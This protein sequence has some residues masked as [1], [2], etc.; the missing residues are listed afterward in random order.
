M[1]VVATTA[2]AL[3]AIVLLLGLSS[4]WLERTPIPLSLLALLYGILLGPA[5]LGV[6]DLDALGERPRILEEI[7]RLALGIGL[8]GVALRVPRSYPREKW[9][10]QLVLIGLGMPL[11]WLVSAALIFLILGLPLWLAALIG[12]IVTPTDPI[13]AGPIVTGPAAEEN[14]PERVRHAISFESG[15]NDGLSYLLVFLPFL[16]L[17]R[18]VEEAL[19][20]WLIH[21]LL[22]EVVFATVVGVS[23]GFVAAR[24][25]QAAEKRD[26]M[27]EDW[28]LVYTVALSLLALGMGRLLG[29]DELL[30]AF[31]AGAAFVQVV[32]EEDRADEERGQ[33]ALNR[34]FALPIFA[35]LGAT[36]PW[37][38]WRGLG[39]SGVLLAFAV[40]LLRRPP[41]LLLLRPWLRDLRGVPDALFLGWFGPIAV[42]AI[43]YASIMEHQL[44]EPLVWEVATLLIVA[45]VLAH[46]TTATPLTELYG[47]RTG[48]RARLAAEKEAEVASEP[49][50]CEPAERPG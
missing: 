17:T 28:R 4:K 41:V 34:F 11:M 39:W 38:G 7:A 21:T 43:Y 23:M 13:A 15:A 29:S 22:W 31:A 33:E 26:M 2:A 6:F 8:V 27:E 16:I 42:A 3:G 30:V 18:P 50:S 25:L 35:V 44:G 36:I 5:G 48:E 47:E 40:L 10:T 20:H 14:L 46:G 19:S 24:L 9:R 45:S 32:S 37:E 12:A 49:G 1:D